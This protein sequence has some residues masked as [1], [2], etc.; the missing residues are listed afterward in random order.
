[1]SPRFPGLGVNGNVFSY[2]VIIF[3]IFSVK[4]YFEG[5]L[6]IILPLCC[7]GIIFIIT[8]K[9]SIFSSFVIMLSF[10]IFNYFKKK[11]DVK[12]RKK[13]SKIILFSLL[14]IATLVVL[15]S[16]FFSEYF[17]II[18]RIDEL[19]G[20]SEQ[21][22]SINTRNELWSLGMERVSLSPFL[23]IDIVQA[24][25]L[26]DTNI[27][28][29]GTPHNEFIFYWMTLGILGVL[30]YI[31]FILYLLLKNIYRK[32][33]LEWVL[34]YCTLILQMIFDGAFQTLRFQ[35]LFFIL[36]GLNFKEINHQLEK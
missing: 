2:M 17:T 11:G 6:S 14:I 34:L 30:G 16:Y 18:D 24:D 33:R 5:R 29:F 21:D 20:N 36:V 8:S 19:I 4:N 23:G 10:S 26:S 3:L 31:I 32:F 25:M 35:F 9:T 28:Y 12:E 27:L 22:N 15:I 13:K 1:M 7:I